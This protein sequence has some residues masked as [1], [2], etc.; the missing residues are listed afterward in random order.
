MGSPVAPT[1]AIITAMS[2]MVEQDMHA[3]RWDSA[4]SLILKLIVC[5]ICQ[6]RLRAGAVSKRQTLLSLKGKF[7]G[8]KVHEAVQAFATSL[9][10]LRATAIFLCGRKRQKLSSLP[11]LITFPFIAFDLHDASYEANR[12]DVS[13]RVF[14]HTYV[15]AC[16]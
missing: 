3:I 16:T 13:G 12:S 7:L 15:Y 14:V 8:S 5:A 2:A 6:Q 11:S 1:Q 4:R 10:C 9:T